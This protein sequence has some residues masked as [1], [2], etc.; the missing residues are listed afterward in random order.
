MTDTE[1]F[2][3]WANKGHWSN[4]ERKP[5]RA[6][7]LRHLV[8]SHCHKLPTADGIGT[9]LLV[10]SMLPG[11]DAVG[12]VYVTGGL[13]FLR[14]HEMIE[15]FYKRGGKNPRSFGNQSVHWVNPAFSDGLDWLSK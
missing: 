11:L 4:W 14:K 3:Q 10:E 13:A 7:L 15:G 1:T 12:R 5:E 6:E 8:M 9:T 2:Q